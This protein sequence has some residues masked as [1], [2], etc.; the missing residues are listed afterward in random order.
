MFQFSQSVSHV[1]VH[2]VFLYNVAN[3]TFPVIV[4]S[5]TLHYVAFKFLLAVNEKSRPIIAENTST[6]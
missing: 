6:L 4:L 3:Q 2:M 5:L 1:V